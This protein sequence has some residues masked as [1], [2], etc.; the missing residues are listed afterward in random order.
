MLSAVG[1]CL[2]AMG[3]LGLMPPSAN[4]AGVSAF[5]RCLLLSLGH[6]LPPLGN[7]SS[8]SGMSSSHP[9]PQAE[10]KSGWCTEDG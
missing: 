10:V 8:L 7:R 2:G 4:G 3:L 6:L 1:D 9:A 5:L